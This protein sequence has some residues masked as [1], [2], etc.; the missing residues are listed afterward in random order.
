[1]NDSLGLQAQGKLEG[2]TGL[3]ALPVA[4]GKEGPALAA[5]PPVFIPGDSPCLSWPPG[6]LQP[7]ELGVKTQAPLRAS[8]RQ[9]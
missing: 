3:R 5:R 4:P 2:D 9:L 7:V 8:D 6:K 1:M